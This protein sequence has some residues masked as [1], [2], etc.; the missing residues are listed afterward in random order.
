MIRSFTHHSPLSLLYTKQ[1][2]WS[3]FSGF[4]Q[5]RGGRLRNLGNHRRHDARWAAALKLSP[6]ANEC[7]V[8][9]PRQSGGAVLQKSAPRVFS[10]A[11]CFCA[12]RG[13]LVRRIPSTA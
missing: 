12:A 2:A 10:S 13:R 11:T 8:G 3:V 5:V 7:A 4:S 6:P 9:T 1:L